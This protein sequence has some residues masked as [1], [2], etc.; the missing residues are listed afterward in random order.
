MR[1]KNTIILPI[2]CTI[3]GFAGY[4]IAVQQSIIAGFAV[5]VL[6]TILQ[7]GL[8]TYRTLRGPG[9]IS[10]FILRGETYSQSMFRWIE[11]GVLPEGNPVQVLLFHLI[12][13]AVYCVLAV[14]TAN[15][16]SMILGCVLLNYMNFYVANLM[17]QSRNPLTALIVGWNPWSIIRV[18][19]FLWLGSNFG[20]V[21]LSA[22]FSVPDLKSGY[23]YA[24]FIGVAVDTILKILCSEPWRLLIKRGLKSR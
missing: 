6:W 9:D 10:R 13:A 2:L 22:F 8:V 24:G 21:L 16:G 4:V 18:A 5:L 23:L 7:S 20:T 12:Q 1:L 17:L 15:F 3:P 14:C 11:T 19:A